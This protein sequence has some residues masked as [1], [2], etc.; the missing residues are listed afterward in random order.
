[1]GKNKHR[2]PPH[3]PSSPAASAPSPNGSASPPAET[4]VTVEQA[5]EIERLVAVAE[6][7]GVEPPPPEQA[8]PPTSAAQAVSSAQR[9]ERMFDAARRQAE[10]ARQ[11]AQEEEHALQRQRA[12]AEQSLR[13]QRE[14]LSRQ[15][16]ELR[17]RKEELDRLE[18]QALEKEDRLREREQNAELGFVEQR[19]RMVTTLEE[20]IEALRAE[21]D[22]LAAAANARRSEEEAAWRGRVDE[23]AAQWRREEGERSA[24][25]QE[26]DGARAQAIAKERR[27]VMDE[28]EA[29]RVQARRAREQ[30]LADHRVRMAS[31]EAGLEAQ[32]VE[33]TAERKEIRRARTEVTAARDVVEED[34]RELERK[35]ERLNAARVAELEAALREEQQKLARVAAERERYWGELESRRE[36]ER[37]FGDKTPEQILDRLDQLEREAGELGAKLR[38]SPGEGAGRRLAE[39]EKE[40]SAWLDEQAALRAQLADKEAHLG[41]LRIA[42]VELET[43]R[44]RAEALTTSKRLLE[45]ALKDLRA[46]VDRYTQADEKRNPME[47]LLALDRSQDLQSEVRTR[48]PLAGAGQTVADFT[49]RLH[50]GIARGLQNKTLHYE[51]RDIRCF[52]AGLAMS[53]LILLQGI[54]GTGKTSLPLAFAAATGAG[55]EVV[56][57]QAGWRDRQDLIGYYN[58]FHRHFYATNFLQALYRA[59]TPK[60]RD[61]PFLIV[62]DEINL[63]RVEQFFAD[64]LSA[65]EQ[66]EEEKRRLTLLNDP[67]TDPPRLMV[68]G[69]HLPIPPNVWFIGTANHDE[70]TTE[71]ADKTYDRAHVMELPR[72][73]TRQAGVQVG[74]PP[75]AREPLSCKGLVDV[76]TGAQQKQDA[77]VK[78]VLDW[79]RADDGIAPLLDR[80]FRVGWGNRLE[81]D[82]ERFVPVVVEAGGTVGEALD[83]LLA[84]KVLRKLRNRHDVSARN[85]DE[86]QDRIKATWSDAPRELNRSLDL[87]DRER[88]AKHDEETGG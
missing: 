43:L 75:G 22:A 7:I 72:R 32:R 59:G 39:L 41:R 76:F 16:G 54:S 26:E 2:P 57:V 66:P 61:R 24:R 70:T 63:S 33:L 27:R 12:D 47:A 13:K 85:L 52:I 5:I 53:R 87:I 28:L 67:I 78:K 14:E 6:V 86:L 71:F 68:D 77:A 82:V 21:Q 69:R 55:C 62:L 31:E 20:Q 34:G 88:R 23:R 48:P 35:V 65:L 30:E 80:R 44:D 45:A 46:E 4:S 36:L 37:R 3:R 18:M 11:K 8:P 58:A 19:R 10:A 64:F 9:A 1:M 25:W 81:R 38:A 50:Q 51:A 79:L 83:H 56:E 29:E 42:A 84:T 73:N 49:A 17:R 60:Y 74:G 40:R 15:E